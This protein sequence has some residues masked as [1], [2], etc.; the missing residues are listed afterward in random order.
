MGKGGTKFDKN[1]EKRGSD[2]EATEIIS[3]PW[4]T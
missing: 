2:Q 3:C 4:N 1:A